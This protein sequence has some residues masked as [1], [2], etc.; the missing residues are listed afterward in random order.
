MATAADT[1]GIRSIRRA[2]ATLCLVIFLAD[3]VFGIVAPTF[4]LFAKGL[5]VTVALIGAINT[6]GSFAQLLIAIPIGLASDR[7]S[8][9]RIV[10]LGMVVYAGALG[11]FAIAQ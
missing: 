10:T 2:I 11:C 8:R 3:V 1:G 6:I 5:G 9:P 4:S 7:V